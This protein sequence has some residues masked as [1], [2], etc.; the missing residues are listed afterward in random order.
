MNDT[1]C[2]YVAILGRP[3]VGKS[4]LLNRLVGE[5]VSIVTHK[6]QTTRHN[7]YGIKTEG[8]RQA[9]FIDTPG[10]HRGGQHKLNRYMNQ[11]AQSIIE[12][13]DVILFL[14]DARCW[15]EEDEMVLQKIKQAKC[16]V[17]LVVNKID[18]FKNKDDLL[19]VLQNLTAK[20]NFTEIIPV[21]AV[22]QKNLVELDRVIMKYLPKN[23]HFFDE[24]EI[25]NR[26]ENFLIAEIIREK[27]F[28][29]VHQEI[30][31][32][33][34]VSI[35]KREREGNLL[36]IYA[37]IYV[38]KPGQKVII[39]GHHGDKIKSIGRSARLELERKY[40]C[41]V[42]LQLWVKIKEDWTNDEKM[43]QNS[44]Q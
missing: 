30:P 32:A 34:T 41:K 21:S 8:D 39:I 7:I 11:S 37:T 16:P 5:K 40:S 19:P 22:K 24:D 6:R 13:V 25:T 33:S 31:Y 3:N 36:K 1:Y 15:T 10:M 29:E 44:G 4:T 17:F 9:I 18:E 38:E 43:I 12:D 2:G 20:F 23:P 26:K 42:F 27:I 14:V 28:K 35:E